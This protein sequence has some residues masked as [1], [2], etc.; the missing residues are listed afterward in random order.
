MDGAAMYQMTFRPSSA[1][2]LTLA[3]LAAGAFS[4]CNAATEADRVSADS[5]VRKRDSAPAASIPDRTPG[6][7]ASA[8]G[9]AAGS[10]SIPA[11]TIG[12]GR[13]VREQPLFQEWPEPEFVLF[14]TG[15]QSGHIEPCGCTGLDNA[16]GGLVRRFSL[17]QQLTERG[18]NVVPMDVGNQVRRFG[19]QPEIKFQMTT[20][21][22]K[23]MGY[24]AIGF[25]PDDLRL[26][27]GELLGV[28][29]DDG[30]NGTPFVGANT[31]VLDRSLTPQYQ[32]IE[33]AGRRIGVTAVLGTDE[34]AQITSDEIIK[35]SPIEALNTVWPQLQQAD[36]DMYVLLAHTSL[37]DTILL[38]QQF[39]YFDV[40]VTAGGGSEPTYQAEPIPETDSL[41]VQ[42][43]SKGMHVVVVGVFDDEERLRYQRVPLDAR[44]PDAREMLDLLASYQEQLKVA[45]LDGLGVRPIPHPSGHTFVGSDAC[46]D[47][48]VTE[49]DIWEGTHHAHALSSLVYPGER[50][51]IP[52]HF[53]P[54]CI[55]CHV[56]GWD[57]QNHFPFTSGY[58]GL[59]ETPLMHNVGCESCH[60]PGSAHVDAETL[61]RDEELL[62]KLRLGMRLPLAEAERK[63]MECH[64]LDNSPDFHLPGAFERFWERIE[65]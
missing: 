38:A 15:Q 51:E 2:L 46:K 24:Q 20:A 62:Q 52:R 48:H 61:S 22:L 5:G 23:Q 60:G 55:S 56:V 42:V 64:D 6:T 16:L 47:C 11:A 37:K 7:P 43:G 21:G 49:Y 29:A 40:V 27:V 1:Q 41:L 13:P 32:I 19:R 39:P 10:A 53:D 36:C 14:I 44:F 9:N 33:T 34:Q 57:P 18:W 3:V 28:T 25:G 65:H 4:G 45:G 63:C 54:E 12:N 58:L 35:Q 17:K 26:S 50:G 8:G 31:A 30:Q 59:K